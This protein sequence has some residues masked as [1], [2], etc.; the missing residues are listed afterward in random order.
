MIS[1]LMLLFLVQLFVVQK[2]SAQERRVSLHV[3]NIPLSSVLNELTKQTHYKFFYSDNNINPN[4]KVTLNVVNKPL[5]D[6]LD[7]LFK[8]TEIGFQLKNN[9][10]L[11]FRKKTMAP[12]PVASPVSSN[13]IRVTG[14]VTD[15]KGQPLPGVTIVV[16]GTTTG[17]ISD[18]NGVYELNRVPSEG[19]LEY[20]FV[21]MQKQLINVKNKEHINVML[22]E[23]VTGLNEV[24]VLGFGTQKK[25]NVTGAISTV[26][27]TE[28]IKSPVANVTSALIGTTTGV[29]G[30]QMSGEPGQNANQIYIR[31]MSTYGNS[32]PLIVIDGV[33]QPAEQAYTEL[34][35]MDPNEIAGISVLKDA[36]ST[37]VYGIRG[38]NGVI[39]VTTKRGKEGKPVFNLSVNYGY[40]KAVNMLKQSSAYEWASMRNEAINIANN[41]LGNNS[42]SAYL[43]S[44]DQLWKFQ[45]NRDFTPAEVAAM[46]NL[47][48]DQQVQLNASPALYYRNTDITQQLYGNVGPQKQVN[49]NVSG[50]NARVTYYATLGYFTQVG[51]GPNIS[52]G[53]DNTKSSFDRYNFRSN[54]DIHLNKNT[55]IVLNLT[56]QFG[57]TSA[58]GANSGTYGAVSPY[59][60]GTRYQIMDQYLLEGNPM[61]L[62]GIIDG[63]LVSMIAGSA[64][65]PIT[66]PLGLQNVYQNGNPIS[67]ILISGIGTLA[68]TLIDNNLRINH[69]MDYLTKGLSIHATVDYQNNYSKYVSQVYN[70]P[71]YNVQRD[72][73]NPN[74]LD[75]FGGSFGSNSFNSSSYNSTWS[76]IYFDAGIDYNRTFGDH[77]VTAL[78]LGKAQQYSMPSDVFNTPSGLMGL[79]GR[80]TYNYKERYMLEYDLGYNGTEQFASGHRFGYFP[81]Y[82]IG[83]VPTNE[84]FF[85]ENKWVTFL[86][87][88]GSYGEVG[89]DLLGSTGRRYLF[90]PNSYNMNLSNSGSNQGYY[91]GNSNG[92]TV[93]P[94][95]AGAT[96][97]ALGNPIITWEKAKK[98]DVGFDSRFFSDRLSFTA[99]YFHESRSNILTTLGIIPATFGVPWNNIPPANVGETLNQGYELSLGWKDKI[100]QVGYSAHI[101]I[102]YAKNK[103]I[104]MSE[105]PNPYPWMDHTGYPIGQYFG[106]VSNGFFN[107][108]QELA[109]RPYNSYTSNVATLGD[110]RYKDLNGDGFI[111]NKDIAPIGYSNLPQYHF[112]ATLGLN[113]KGIDVSVLFIGTANGSYYLNSGYIIP[114]QKGGL[115]NVWQWEYDGHW[116]AAKAAS[117][118]KITFPRASIDGNSSSN[119]F[120]GSDFWL[121]SNNFFRVKNVEVGYSFPKRLIE[122][123]QLNSLRVYFNATNLFTF[124]NALSQYGVDPEQ[125]D[126]GASYLYPLTKVFNFGLNIQF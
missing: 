47:T 81:A 115:G 54:F 107:T 7:Q 94:Y 20:S 122:H 112:N 19:M 114:F 14:K 22:S 66:N 124:K 78:L 63:K 57:T 28:I 88:R 52:Y 106:L 60:L 58:F 76:K 86:K 42:Y 26:S 87:I 16:K 103:I 50:G 35:G 41:D 24:V 23:M 119:D 72:P 96:E 73:A 56:G 102:S 117:G 77:K 44:P 110:I 1:V 18:A 43:F 2:A 53:G 25:V 69:R 33:E 84:A 39:I 12:I 121:K 59:N 31:G 125:T 99:D 17:T 9:Q 21:G 64:G 67:N 34:N 55:D 104:Y 120:L 126:T 82:S 85:H 62:P 109:N 4:Q 113:Y 68:N 45:N 38:A 3:V 93:N 49:F 91:L 111:N 11:L 36:A 5:N 108:T 32:Q 118:A 30:L 15:D 40:N 92:S 116:T 97:G 70:I 90:L 83:W 95:Y 37:A 6:V 89:N 101:G 27:G 80:L 75:F 123:L 71:S 61:V 79:V 29:S 105:A 100:G 8:E 74:K 51:I 65:N 13:L 10:I 48:P 98:L 46:T